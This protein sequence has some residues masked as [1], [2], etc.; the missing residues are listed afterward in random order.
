MQSTTIDDDLL[1]N[2]VTELSGHPVSPELDDG[3]SFAT[4][5]FSSWNDEFYADH[6]GGSE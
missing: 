3:D 4:G 2:W 1:L 6:S 5:S